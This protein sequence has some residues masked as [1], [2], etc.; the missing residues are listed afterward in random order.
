VGRSE[1]AHL[2]PGGQRRGQFLL[3]H[4]R[5]AGRSIVVQPHGRLRVRR[6]T[7]PCPA[8]ARRAPPR[9]GGPSLCAPVTL[10]GGQLNAVP[11]GCRSY[12]LTGST[13][14]SAVPLKISRPLPNRA[15]QPPRISLAT[16][17]RS[18]ATKEQW[19]PNRLTTSSPRCKVCLT[20]LS[21]GRF[22]LPG[23]LSL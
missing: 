21:S 15:S 14:T 17:L 8:P 6:L 16:A 22:V 19:T 18:R 13:S 12:S 2:R 20:L 4:P 10:A 11:P 23:T 7:L 3:P 5:P 1:D 9:A